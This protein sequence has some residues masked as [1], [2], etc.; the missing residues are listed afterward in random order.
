MTVSTPE[1]AAELRSWVDARRGELASFLSAYIRQRSVNPGRATSADEISG[2]ADAQHWL[3]RQVEEF[4]LGRADMW[5]VAPGRPNLAWTIGPDDAGPGYGIV[6]NGHADTVG[7]SAAQRDE[8]DGDPFGGQIRGGRVT[9]RGAADMKGGIAAFAWAARAL[10]EM[11]VPLRRKAAFTVTVAEETAQ[12]DLGILALI[13]RGYRAPAVVCAEPTDLHICPAGLGIIYFRVTVRGKSAHVASTAG[14]MVALSAFEA[15]KSDT[16]IGVDAIT[17]TSG[18]LTA[19]RTVDERWRA[20]PSHP[21]LP[22]GVGR[23]VCPILV[24]GGNSRAE[25]ADECVAEFA[26]SFDPADD[27]QTAMSEI[28]AAIDE[29]TARSRW[30]RAH[31]PEIALPIVHRLLPPLLT[32]PAEESVRRLARPLAGQH[33]PEVPLGAMPGPCDANVLAEA[34]QRAVVFGP[35]RLGDGAHGSNEHVNI[36][37][38]ATACWIDAC[39]IAEFCG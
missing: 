7:V 29:V 3:A 31:P 8:W 10:R 13:G 34:G 14:S 17:L 35:G 33:G 19:L 20:R 37:D 22:A 23:S 32:D 6:F 15:G 9:G 5:E 26:V 21:L 2:E 30:L 38:L 36:D 28:R 16:L 25:I 24:S 1:L 27:V 11:G 4:G 18:I 39:M 12:S